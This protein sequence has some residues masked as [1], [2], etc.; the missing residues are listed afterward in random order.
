MIVSLLLSGIMGVFL[1]SIGMA[2][3]SGSRNVEEIEKEMILRYTLSKVWKWYTDRRVDRFP[4]KEVENALR[5]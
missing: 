5:I 4:E 2:I 1:G 3:I